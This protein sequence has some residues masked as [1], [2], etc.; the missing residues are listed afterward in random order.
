MRT[1]T[2][3]RSEGSP[4]FPRLFLIRTVVSPRFI[5]TVMCLKLLHHTLMCLLLCARYNYSLQAEGLLVLWRVQM[6]R[7]RWHKPGS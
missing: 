5:R 4:S 1:S 2:A 7:R 3:A 6:K